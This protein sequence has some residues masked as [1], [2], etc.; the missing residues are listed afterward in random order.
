MA[1]PKQSLA[2]NK[3]KIGL[4]DGVGNIRRVQH[5]QEYINNIEC[6]IACDVKFY[7]CHKDMQDLNS[8]P[9]LAR[10]IPEHVFYDRHKCADFRACVQQSGD[11][12]G[13]VPLTAMQSYTGKPVHWWHFHL[14]DSWDKQL[15][16]VRISPGFR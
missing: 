2:G 5:D 6:V 7:D 16:G 12:F 14:G 10:D 1:N 9:S 15:N 13:F 11:T 4:F 8:S 3:N